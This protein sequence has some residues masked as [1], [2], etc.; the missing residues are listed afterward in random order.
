MSQREFK[1]RIWSESGKMHY[2]GFALWGNGNLDNKAGEFNHFRPY[3][4]M[5][6]TG[7]KDSAGREIYEGDIVKH[8]ISGSIGQVRYVSTAFVVGW[9]GENDF[10]DE[11]SMYSEIVEVVG[12]IY[13]NPEM[14]EDNTSNI[15]SL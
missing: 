3:F 12:N 2:N 6:F 15:D 14:L 5:Q 4:I 10:S 7:D 9:N 13:A 8:N 1:F 11:I